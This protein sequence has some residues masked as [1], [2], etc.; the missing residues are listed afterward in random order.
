MSGGG[1]TAVTKDLAS[2]LNDAR[3]IHFDD[4]DIEGPSDICKWAEE[5]ASYDEWNVDPII[6][7]I[8]LLLD[9]NEVIDDYELY[10]NV[11]RKAYKIMGNN[12]KPDADYIIDGQLPIYEI[13]KEII[14][15]L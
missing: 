12:V 4:Y 11:E 8:K 13:V 1:K 6:Q 9:V 14:N 5:S 15:K 7:D 3:V 2:K 10:L